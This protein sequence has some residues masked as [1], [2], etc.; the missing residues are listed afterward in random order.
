M[1]AE[2]GRGSKRR[3]AL[4]SLPPRP[5]LAELLD[6]L[7]LSQAELARRSRTSLSLVARAVRGAQIG[8]ASRAKLVA[9]INAARAAGQLPE[10]A[11]SDDFPSG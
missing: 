2:A 8:A 1:V 11:A 9:A 10:L 3:D 5:P 7:G 4:S 6:E